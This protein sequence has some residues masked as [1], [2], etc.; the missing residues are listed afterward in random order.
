M[1]AHSVLIIAGILTACQ[2]DYP[3]SSNPATDAVS[4]S[5]SQTRIARIA[6]NDVLD[7]IVPQLPG[8]TAV[9]L[10]SSL[11]TLLD[12]LNEGAIDRT[13]LTEALIEVA[14]FNEATTATAADLDVIR[15][16]LATIQR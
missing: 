1:K 11:T 4:L 7:R 12:A 15:L 8:T 2:G 13:A 16:A 10:A 3:T 5:A 14:Q 9:P 6:I